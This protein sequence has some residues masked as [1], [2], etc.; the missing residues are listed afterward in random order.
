MFNMFSR[1]ASDIPTQVPATTA[2]LS[3]AISIV[4]L[5]ILVVIERASKKEVLPISVPVFPAGTIT[6]L[7]AKVLARARA[8]TTLA[9]IVSQMPFKLAIVKTTLMLHLT[10][11]GGLS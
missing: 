7:E 5:A 2:F 3:L 4:P 6:F 1:V 11:E 10:C 9:V 8:A